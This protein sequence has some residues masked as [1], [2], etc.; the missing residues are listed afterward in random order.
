MRW[1]A[2]GIEHLSY[3]T[4]VKERLDALKRRRRS[5]LHDFEVARTDDVCFSDASDDAVSARGQLREQMPS[6]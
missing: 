1:P 2:K 3:A 6:D 5:K 4:C